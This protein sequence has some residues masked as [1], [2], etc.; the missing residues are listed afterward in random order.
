RHPARTARAISLFQPRECGGYRPRARG[1]RYRSGACVR[2]GAGGVFGAGAHFFAG[3]G[4]PSL[5]G[6]EGMGVGIPDFPTAYPPHH[7]RAIVAAILKPEVPLTV[8]NDDGIVV[9][10]REVRLSGQ[11]RSY[12]QSTV[13]CSASTT[14][15]PRRDERPGGTSG[16]REGHNAE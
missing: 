13:I 4:P 10:R 8:L 9:G 2:V 12:E 15:G 16:C 6:A 5:F 3:W 1:G 11:G 14:A 7:R